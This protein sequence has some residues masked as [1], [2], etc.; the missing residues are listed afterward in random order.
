ML[1]ALTVMLC[2]SIGAS[3]VFRLREANVRREMAM[4][5]QREMADVIAAMADIEVNLSKLLI[6]SGARQSVSLLGETALLAQHVESGLSR[7]AVSEQTAG[8]AMKFAG[9]MG[10]YSLALAAQVSDGGMLTG[11]D[12]RQIEDMMQACHALGQQLAGQGGEISWPDAETDS[13]IEY[14]SLIYDGPFSDGK[15]DRQSA[16]LNTSRFSRQQAREA[17]AKYAGVTVEHVTEA[18]DSGGRFEAFGFT[19][20][21]PDGHIAVQVTGQ[22]GFLLWMMPE[23]AEFAQ[24]RGEE[25][26]LQN[27]K[28]YLADVGFGE[29]EPCFVQ[30]YDGMVVCQFRR[31]AGRRDAVLRSGQGAGEHGQRAR[32][33]RGMLAVP[34]QSYAADRYC[35]DGGRFAGAGNGFQ[36]TE[37]EKRTPVRH[38]SGRGRNPLLGL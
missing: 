37:R 3:G 19:A 6:A 26:C 34:R 5:Q 13:G 10:Q 4:Q 21:T 7:M 33:R 9:Q 31:R 38:S 30:Q 36:Q 1:A 35:A 22:G 12:E 11:D 8:D 16:L 23:N 20:D 28:V 25:E 14:P 17:A 24:R 15:T 27:A 18:A 2:L 29:M 32:G